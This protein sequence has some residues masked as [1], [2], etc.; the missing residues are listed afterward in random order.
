MKTFTQRFFKVLQEQD[1]LEGPVGPPPA[2]D[3]GDVDAAAASLDP[4]TDPA[5]LND[6]GDNPAQ[7]YEKEQDAQ[8]GASLQEWIGSIE[9]FID[10]LNGLD[11]TS[12]N[13]QINNA[14]CD[15]LFE[16]IARSETKKIARI[17]Q[18]LRGLSESLK[19]YLI[20]KET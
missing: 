19:S 18:D 8:M 7:A 14:A 1:E 9:S 3:L 20:S 15:S 12:I 6:V 4:A 11:E 5:M 17:A 16:D 10:T 13:S 2:E